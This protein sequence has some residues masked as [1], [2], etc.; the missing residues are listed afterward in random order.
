[1]VTNVKLLNLMGSKTMT[2]VVTIDSKVYAGGGGGNLGGLRKLHEMCI[3]HNI[4][5]NKFIRVSQLAHL[6]DGTLLVALEY[7]TCAIMAVSVTNSQ[8]R[9]YVLLGSRGSI[10]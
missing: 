4:Y 9:V 1:M 10:A 5:P 7:A 6:A 8:E 2:M 3:I